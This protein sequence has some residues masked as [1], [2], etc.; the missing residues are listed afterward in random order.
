MP[1]NGILAGAA[2]AGGGGNTYFCTY[3]VTESDPGFRPARTVTYGLRLVVGSNTTQ[4]L[5]LPEIFMRDEDDD[6]LVHISR[7]IGQRV[8][9]HFV[10]ARGGVQPY[11][12]ELECALPRGLGFSPDTRVLSGTPLETYRGPHCTYRVTDSATP[13]TTDAR[14]VRLIIEPLDLE[15]WRFRTRTVEPGGICALPNP[16]AP[17]TPVAILPHAQ[18]GEAG[19]DVYDLIDFPN[20]HFLRL[21]PGHAPTHVHSPVCGSNP[22]YSQYIPLSG[23]QRA[24]HQCG[25]RVVARICR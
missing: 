19:D 4:P 15:T 24:A 14:S 5:T 2:P 13:P 8:T 17:P 16:G 23:R 25:P 6:P 7:T 22:W 9:I 21:R 1:D 12:Y 3:R 18:G 20:D 11:T 10:P